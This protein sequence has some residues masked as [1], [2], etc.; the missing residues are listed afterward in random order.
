MGGEAGGWRALLL[1]WCCWLPSACLP[2]TIGAGNLRLAWLRGRS[3]ITA[4]VRAWR[5]TPDTR[6]DAS[7]L[8]LARLD[9][10]NAP[11]APLWSHRHLKHIAR[12]RLAPP[13]F[14]SPPRW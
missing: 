14:Q 1:L 12:Y 3:R 5:L 7:T 4:V 6:F 9:A 10:S 2:T 11:R 8:A 13:S